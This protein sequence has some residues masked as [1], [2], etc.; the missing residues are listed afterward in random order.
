MMH[1]QRNYLIHPS[2][3]IM[4]LMIAG[5]TALFLGFTGAYIYNR[6]EQGVKPVD[7]P[8]LFY[9]NTL[10]I[11]GSSI[12]LI[13]AKRAY[14]NDQTEIFKRMLLTTLVLTIIFL[15]AQIFAW[16]QLIGQNILINHST[17]AS[18][19]YLIS[20]VHFLH[21]VGGLPFLA[22]FLYK[23]NKNLKD[24]VTVLLYFSDP[25]RKRSL[26]LLNIYWH[27]L[28]GL[29]IYLVIFFLINYLIG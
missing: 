15:I 6:I 12:T 5:I 13:I 26:N 14:L 23:A 18:Y 7:L 20:G 25:D 24:P 22:I 1:Q 10:I 27:F 19:M 21:L 16:L 28:D 11:I 3:I 2:Y 17:L 29:W 4:F 9:L 8:S